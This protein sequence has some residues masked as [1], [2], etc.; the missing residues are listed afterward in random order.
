MM[1]KSKLAAFI[2]A[3]VFAGLSFAKP[4]IPV[5]C[6]G[7]PAVQAEGFTL[8][9][10][11][12]QGIYI[13][14]NTSHYDTSSNWVFFLGPISARSDESALIQG[15]QILSTLNPGKTL[16]QEDEEGSW[17]CQY[18]TGIE[19]LSAVAVQVDGMISPFKMNQYL[20]KN[21]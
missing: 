20:R 5:I 17:Y 10:E 19:S 4:S 11:V 7:M 21:Y 6:P 1:F 9:M 15:N 8:S 12:F 2:G 13:T 18:E 14:Y 16:P 3:V